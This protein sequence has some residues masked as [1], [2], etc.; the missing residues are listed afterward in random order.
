MSKRKDASE[1][2]PRDNGHDVKLNLPE[3]GSQLI[4]TVSPNQLPQRLDHGD[5][6]GLEAQYVL[7]LKNQGLGKV[8]GCSQGVPYANREKI[9]EA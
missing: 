8:E 4:D 1:S 9:I 6:L 2:Q 5:G 3:R 7:G